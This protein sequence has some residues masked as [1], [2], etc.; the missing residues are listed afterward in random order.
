MQ[1]FSNT[2]I[3]ILS[4]KKTN[5]CIFT[6]FNIYNYFTKNHTQKQ[7]YKGSQKTIH[8][9]FNYCKQNKHKNTTIQYNIQKQKNVL[10]NPM[11]WKTFDNRYKKHTPTRNH[12]PHRKIKNTNG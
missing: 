6:L 11:F 7:T 12:K 3:K 8:K 9:K 2:I 5:S 4:Q 10:N 1:M